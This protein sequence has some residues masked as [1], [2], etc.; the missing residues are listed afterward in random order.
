M[1]HVPEIRATRENEAMEMVG[2]AHGLDDNVGEQTSDEA[3][4]LDVFAERGKVAVKRA[5]LA[6]GPV[7]VGVRLRRLNRHFQLR[8]KSTGRRRVLGFHRH[9][10][11]PFGDFR[12]TA[13]GNG[14]QLRIKAI[15]AE[16][17]KENGFSV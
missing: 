7:V 13:F 16:C 6:A 11:L 5:Q 14:V 3:L 8:P 15:V 9:Q 1:K 10:D 4:E 2:G 17:P 12:L